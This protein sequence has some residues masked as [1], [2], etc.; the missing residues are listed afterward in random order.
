VK[1]QSRRGY[2]A[3]PSLKGQD[4]LPYELAGMNA[5]SQSPL[6]KAFPMRSAAFQFRASAQSTEVLVAFEVP[7][8]ELKAETITASQAF[9][10]HPAFLAIIKDA[11]GEVAAKV[12]RDIPFQAPADKL[13][14]F[15]AGYV[16]V[17]L[18]VSLAPGRYTAETA[19]VDELA[20]S[21]AARRS[22]L[23][24]S[25]DVDFSL[26]DLLL[27]RRAEPVTTQPDSMGGPLE[28]SGRKVTPALDGSMPYDSNGNVAL[29]FVAY[30]GENAKPE[31]R[32]EIMH[33]GKPAGSSVQPVDPATKPG[34]PIPYFLTIPMAKLS[35]GNY[36]FTVTMQ[37]GGKAISHTT[38]VTLK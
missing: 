21:A 6:P 4:L 20:V 16:S 29:Y 34:E 13:E 2:Y 14:A 25:S 8:R 24:V 37:Q 11:A 5:L 3:L 17:T 38:V 30:P 31:I 33:D 1:V 28:L 26:S 9:K 35:P 22:V 27:V 18:P 23:V 36:E 7:T 19:V 10:I 15:R 12:S 32:M